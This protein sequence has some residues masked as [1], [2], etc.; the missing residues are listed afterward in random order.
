MSERAPR[1]WGAGGRYAEP[2]R[3]RAER[4]GDETAA[5][6]RV[7]GRA[8]GATATGATR[9]DTRR[10]CAHLFD[11]EKYH[12]KTFPNASIRIRAARPAPWYVVCAHALDA[13]PSLGL[14]SLGGTHLAKLAFCLYF[15]ESMPKS[16]FSRPVYLKRVSSSPP[17]FSGAWS[18]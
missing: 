10:R 3:E 9:A 12:C 14:D 2:G 11:R 16:C 1:A 5:A 6:S 8:S 18:A 17:S 4:R 13:L 7:G 15:L